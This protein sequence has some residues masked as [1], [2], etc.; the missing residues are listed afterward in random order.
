MKQQYIVVE[1]F[2]LIPSPERN[3]DINRRENSVKNNPNKQRFQNFA[4]YIF[5]DHDTMKFQKPQQVKPRC[6]S[7]AIMKGEIGPHVLVAPVLNT[8]ILSTSEILR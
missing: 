7:W 2:I 3:P 4:S 6:F 1:I 8:F 5:L